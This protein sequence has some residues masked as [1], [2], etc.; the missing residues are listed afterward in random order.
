V[1][2]LPAAPAREVA[3]ST[4]RDMVRLSTRISDLQAELSRAND[5]A[6]R[7]AMEAERLK[8][9]LDALTSDEAV[10]AA[11][12]VLVRAR[13]ALGSPLRA[14]LAAARKAVQG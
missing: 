10:E 7:A 13:P 1:E 12:V 4:A 11:R 14:A 9:Q 6:D 2:A 8:A 3:M 5:R